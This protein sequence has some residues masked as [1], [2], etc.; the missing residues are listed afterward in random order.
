MFYGNH[1]IFLINQGGG[2]VN[3]SND[4]TTALKCELVPV[5]VVK[6]DGHNHGRH[7]IGSI[8]RSL[9]EARVSKLR[10]YPRNRTYARRRIPRP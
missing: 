6:S 5:T 10:S 7:Y 4:T 3:W 2:W 1:N 9:R 8:N